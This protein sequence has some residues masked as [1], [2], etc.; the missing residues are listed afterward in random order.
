MKLEELREAAKV[1][2]EPD[3]PKQR[4]LKRLTDLF[5]RGVLVIPKGT[6]IRPLEG[7]EG[8]WLISGNWAIADED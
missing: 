6:D 8:T 3:T 1:G 2:I 7:R 5:Q 4:Q